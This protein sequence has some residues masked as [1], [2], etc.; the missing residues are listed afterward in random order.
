ML[1]LVKEWR[2]S[3]FAPQ[4][5]RLNFLTP[6]ISSYIKIKISL[7]SEGRLRRA[8]QQFRKRLRK[9]FQLL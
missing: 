1:V 9:N 7:T 3:G 6:C 2:Q 5:N 8:Y 4:D